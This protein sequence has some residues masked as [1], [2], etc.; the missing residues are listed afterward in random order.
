M[1]VMLTA[2]NEMVKR[3]VLCPVYT[4]TSLGCPKRSFTEEIVRGERK[5]ERKI[6]RR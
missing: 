4:V 5:I 6:E 2:A 1:L 3:L